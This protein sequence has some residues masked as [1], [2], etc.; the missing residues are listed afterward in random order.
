MSPTIYLR[1]RTRQIGSPSDFQQKAYTALFAY[2]DASQSDRGFES[3]RVVNWLLAEE[4][5]NSARR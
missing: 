4:R 3:F 1:R 5:P 2:R